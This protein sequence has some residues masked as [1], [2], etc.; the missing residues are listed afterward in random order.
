MV[1]LGVLNFVVFSFKAVLKGVFS[2][3]FK[4]LFC[5]CSWFVVF[6]KVFGRFL[7]GFLGFVG[8]FCEGFHGF[9]FSLE[10]MK[11]TPEKPV[12]HERCLIFVDP[13][14][15]LLAVVRRLGRAS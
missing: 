8:G 13:F 5:R 7:G 12:L 14:V 3:F 6:L 10:Y 4:G 15:L 11:T 2:R 9:R 1:S